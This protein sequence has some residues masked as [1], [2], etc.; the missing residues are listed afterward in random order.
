[1]STDASLDGLIAA[2]ARR[3]PGAPAVEDARESL[4]YGELLARADGVAERLRREGVRPGDV[5]AAYVERSAAAVVSLLG[6]LRAGAAYVALDPADPPARHEAILED[7]RARAV[8]PLD[9]EPVAVDGPRDSAPGGERLAYVM[10]TSGST[11]RPKGVE[12]THA[13][14]L[15]LLA[16]G[17]DVVP[18][19]DDV[20]LLV[21]PLTFDISVLELW[22]ALVQGA[23]LV[24]AAPGR[25]D[26]RAV[27]R[28]V[29]ERGVTFLSAASGVLAR[30]VDDALDD[31][32]GVRIAVS[33]ADVAVPATARRLHAAHP[34]VRL[35]NG[36]GP[37]ETTV[38]CTAHEVREA[39]GPLPIGRPLPG[40]TAR[41]A[42]D[43]ELLIGGPGVARGYRFN[44]AATA[45]RFVDGWYRTG[46]NVRQDA[47]GVLHFLGRLDRQVKIGGVRVEPGEIEH[48]LASHPGV[49]HAAVTVRA[50]VA[51][52][53]QL[54][55]YASPVPGA[56][57]DGEALRAYVAE[58]LPR[59]YVPWTV[60][61][62][63]SMPLTERG[64]VDRDALPE[65]QAAAGGDG[66]PPSAEALRVAGVMGEL[67]GRELPGP[68]DDFFALGGDSLL[69]IALVGRLR[70]LGHAGLGVGAV[71]ARRTPRAL[72]AALEDATGPVLPAI[73][74]RGGSALAPLTGAQ[75]RGWLFG[76]MNPG[77]R[78]YQ[79]AGLVRIDGALDT[80][81]LRTALEALVDRH[82]ALRSSIVVREGEPLQRVHERVALPLEELDLRGAGSAAFARTVRSRARVRIDLAE[83]P[84]VRW[85]LMRLADE[86]WALL[87][88]EHHLA[89]DG[90]SFD[91]LTRELGALYGGAT[92]PPPALQVGDV[93]VW[94]AANAEALD[95]QLVHWAEVL[96][97]DPELLR[98]PFDRPRAARESFDGGVVRHRLG[99]ATARAVSALAEEEGATLFQACL[100]AFAVQ[101]ARYDGRDDV[102]VGTGVANR[103]DPGV[104]GTLGML[105]NTIALR[106]DLSGDPSVREAIRRVRDAVIDGLS[107]ADVPFDRVV[108]RLAP[109]RDPSR[110]PL[111]QT[112]FSFHDAPR[113]PLAWPGVEARV[114]HALPDGTAK[115]DL[116]V[117]AA[118]LADG[119]VSFVWE[120]VD[121]FSDATAARIAAHHA[122][123][124]EAFV[125]DP[126]APALALPLGDPA[127]AATPA[128][129]DPSAALPQVVA[130]VA[131]RARGAAGDDLR[132]AV[133][134]RGRIGRRAAGGG[135]GA[136]RPRRPRAAALRRR[137]RRP[138]RGRAR[139]RGHGGP[140]PRPPGGAAAR[141]PRG[142]R[143]ARGDRRGRRAR[144]VRARSG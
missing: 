18:R 51:G 125:A 42:D 46:D 56:A 105:V 41:V 15:T 30:L 122:R 10:Y 127:S 63:D 45:E 109:P 9:P 93:A 119:S 66:A 24:V 13:N 4:T 39:D 135:R 137:D 121:A 32:A 50:A 120:H 5:V 103:G 81:A 132:R 22:G 20:V 23:R 141:D 74:P 54:T 77:A 8:L 25:P 58:R 129:H 71:F 128:R 104:A 144:R 40:Y 6:V 82:E 68:D 61:A 108:D 133:G 35:I 91:V 64:K 136:R 88:L 59:A 86:R 142:G 2:H 75:R 123:L 36:Y 130:R 33:S 43:G 57:L 76:E 124:L 27:G 90:W 140:R 84:W 101:L 138:P 73:A 118:P 106:V 65:P 72:A 31:L 79:H 139:G 1:M 126:D 89:H 53:Q 62:L 28:L 131:A 87:C 34:H 52:H 95:A 110:S 114:V 85:T 38:L 37:T 98:L 70:A 113:G 55:A 78:A 48:T 67:L 115:A 111:V 21:T 14:V 17:S 143:R 29:R 97:P 100:A 99:A 117:I 80:A 7:A 26:P 16:G 96:D 49:A 134:A 3:D 92:P 102:Q 11:G 60:I 83:A 47:D 12:V 94:E 112:L 69:A 116:N 107:H 44:P 19:R